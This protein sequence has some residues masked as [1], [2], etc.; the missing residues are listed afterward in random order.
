MQHIDELVWE[1]F[2][3]FEEAFANHRLRNDFSGAIEAYNLVFKEASLKTREEPGKNMSEEGAVFEKGLSDLSN[4]MNI[5]SMKESYIAD[6]FRA[7]GNSD[8]ERNHQRYKTL[9]LN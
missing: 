4:L 3:G 9:S 6:A 8:E 5:S 1:A 7:S 2:Q